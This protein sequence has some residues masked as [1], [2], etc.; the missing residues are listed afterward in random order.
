MNSRGK[1]TKRRLRKEAEIRG[2]GKEMSRRGGKVHIHN[3]K[4]TFGIKDLNLSIIFRLISRQS[5]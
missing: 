3:F 4:A 1:E 5:K 2:R